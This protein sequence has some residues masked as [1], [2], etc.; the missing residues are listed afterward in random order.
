MIKKL[1]LLIIFNLLYDL[2]YDQSDD[3]Y[4]KLFILYIFKLLISII[5][6]L[7]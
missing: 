2:L 5:L 6:T 1:A 7:Y 3:I 4:D